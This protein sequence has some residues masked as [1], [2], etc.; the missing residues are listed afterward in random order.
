M[1][2]EKSQETDAQV[3]WEDQQNI[4]KF[5]KLVQK[6]DY[7]EQVQADRKQELELLIDLLAEIELNDEEEAVKYKIGEA[8][9]QMTTAKA[10]EMIDRKESELKENLK[11]L[12]DE[13]STINKELAKLKQLLYA[14]FGNSINLE[15][16]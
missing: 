2:L 9:I 3:S 11:D 14:K 16:Q 6:L 15:R 10:K 4:N 1:I 12:D 5:S 7:I 8:F 13:Q